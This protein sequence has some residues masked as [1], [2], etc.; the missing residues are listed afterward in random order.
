LF[1][2]AVLTILIGGIGFGGLL[3]LTCSFVGKF[4]AHA[5]PP[6]LAFGYL[7]VAFSI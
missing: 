4:G 1:F 7:S 2:V 3:A 5:V 6:G